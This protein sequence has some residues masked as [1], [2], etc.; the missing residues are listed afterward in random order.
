MRVG[1]VQH[2]ALKLIHNDCGASYRQ[3]VSRSYMEYLYV[4]R[5][6]HILIEVNKISHKL[7]PMYLHGLFDSAENE[8]HSHNDALKP[9]NQ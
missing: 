3:A 7:G 4:P 6:L 9:L 1:K 2:S 8:G 5:L